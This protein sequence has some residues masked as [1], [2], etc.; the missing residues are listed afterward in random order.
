V[1]AWKEINY[2]SMGE[3]E[4]MQLVAEVNIL[5]DLRHTNVVRYYERVIDKENM[6]LYIV[7][8]YCDGGDLTAVLR[9]LRQERCVR[10]EAGRVG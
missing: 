9:K 10:E 8:E 3:K 6:R 2:A 4:K 5:R 7:M 1:L